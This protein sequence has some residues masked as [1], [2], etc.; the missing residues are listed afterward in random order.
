MSE[1]F[2]EGEHCVVS[3]SAVRSVWLELDLAPSSGRFKLR[4]E[5]RVWGTVPAR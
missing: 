5:L 4:Q 2:M 1:T 3:V